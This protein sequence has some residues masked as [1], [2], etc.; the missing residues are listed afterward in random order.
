MRAYTCVYNTRTYKHAYIH[1]QKGWHTN[2]RTLQPRLDDNHRCAGLCIS[3]NIHTCVHIHMT[4]TCCS[5][6]WTAI[7][8][9]LACLFLILFLCWASGSFVLLGWA[10]LQ[11]CVCVC[12]CMC[13]RHVLCRCLFCTAPGSLVLLLW[14]NIH[15]YFCACVCLCVCANTKVPAYIARFLRRRN[16]CTLNFACLYS[17]SFL[18]TC[19][20][21]APRTSDLSR[22]SESSHFGFDT[23]IE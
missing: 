15:A 16:S 3:I 20:V 11:N 17:L 18:A 4:H 12:I 22:V 6:T 14:S 8:Y 10:N 1:I 21:R 9:P 23:C 19:F 2:T 13:I 5:Q 7:F